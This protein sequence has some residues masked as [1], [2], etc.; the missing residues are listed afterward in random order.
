MM[1]EI[2]KKDKFIVKQSR[3]AAMGEMISM[4]AHQWRQPL[5]G[6][7]MTTNNLLLDIELEEIDPKKFKENLEIINTQ[8]NFLSNT[9]DNFKNFFETTKR[10]EKVDINSVIDESL[11]IIQNS[12]KNENIN[13]QLNTKRSVTAITKKSELMQIILNLIKKCNGCLQR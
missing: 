10:S 1:N 7:G 11:L 12:I 8:I 3:L 6:M 4:I 5:T 9:I 13:I 2:A